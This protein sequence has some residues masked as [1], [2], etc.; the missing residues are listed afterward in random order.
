M[1]AADL[2]AMSDDL[3]D[4]SKRNA[5]RLL[6]ERWTETDAATATS[7]RKR[8][9]HAAERGVPHHEFGGYAKIVFDKSP[10]AMDHR[11]DKLE[12]DHVLYWYQTHPQTGV[13]RYWLP[14]GN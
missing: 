8:A 1:N 7:A 2:K 14:T 10:F 13:T 9:V 12:I 5:A 11:P 4:T 3:K 6:Q